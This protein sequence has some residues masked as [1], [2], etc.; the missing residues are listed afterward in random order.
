MIDGDGG[1]AFQRL[2]LSLLSQNTGTGSDLGL[3]YIRFTTL[4]TS[5]NTLEI[6]KCIIGAVNR[7]RSVGY[8]EGS[9]WVSA[10]NG[11]SGIE[12]FVN[13]VADN[14]C[15]SYTNAIS[16]AS[17]VGLSRYKFD[18]GDLATLTQSH[19]TDSFS[20]YN[21]RIEM[22]N[23]S[24]PTYMEGA[25]I[26]G[27]CNGPIA[28]YVRDCRIGT[29]SNA[30][31]LNKGAVFVNSGLVNLSLLD[32]AGAALDVEFLDCHG[33]TQGSMFPGGTIDFGTTAGTNHEV[34]FQR[35][36][37][38]VTIVNLK[39][40]DT[41]YAHGNGTFILD[42]SCTGGSFRVA[43]MINL[44]DNSSLVSVSEDG[45]I[46]KS[47]IADAVWDE[48]QPDHTT[49][50]TMGERMSNVDDTISNVILDI[51]GLNDFDPAVDTV[52]RVTLVDT[53]T[54]LTNGG[55][56]GSAHTAQDVANL[57]LAV[58]TT[59]LS[60]TASGS[61][62]LVDTTTNLTNG[63]SGGDDAATIY[64]YFT[65]GSNEDAFKAN[66]SGMAQESS[67]TA[68]GTAV[69]SVNSL[70]QLT[71]TNT[72]SFFTS[73]SNEDVFK[74]DV[75][76]LATSA[77]LQSVATVVIDTN[78]D[79]NALNDITPTDVWNHT[80]INGILPKSAQVYANYLFNIN[81]ETVT[82]KIDQMLVLN[83]EGTEY[84]YT[85]DALENGP[86]G[87]GGGSC[88]TAQE[89]VDTWGNQ[90]QGSYTTSGTLGFY[91]DAQVSSAGG[92]G[93]GLYQ[94]TVRVQD[95][96][97]NALQGA[98][99]NVDGTTLTLTTDSSGEVTFNLDSGVYLLEVSPP[100][101]YDTPT[102]QVLTVSTSDPTTTAFTLTSTSPPTGC[103]IPWIG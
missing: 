77:S 102:G 100:A 84:Q 85:V 63:G 42:A 80:D 32:Q 13:G 30:L 51:A 99:V 94:A 78:A 39:A 97:S 19:S 64:S 54:D 86:S 40:G 69:A 92:S 18:A 53:T 35:W 103:D 73:G 11:V 33:N 8:S 22:N 12:P 65:N 101:G 49:A 52:A 5:P 31:T 60:N 15:T 7:S 29:L 83:G 27:T 36:G 37:G 57:I 45:R 90:S 38:P 24:P 76:A 58:P 17:S 9:V 26:T 47:G 59:P 6:D 3:V 91:L 70:V 75:S 96:S 95:N 34:S 74:A 21:Y 98:R 62:S 46:T 23:Q 4:G 68:V 71:P 10:T 88:P 72:Y 14:P 28:H 44:V 20:G 25:E 1:G 66:V 93:T 81:I 55:G 41:V 43:G 2:N 82:D 56:G 50:G 89:I 87:G 79:V 16:I 48:S 67:V 61:L